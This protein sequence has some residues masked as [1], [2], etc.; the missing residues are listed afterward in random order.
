MLIWFKENFERA[1]LFLVS[2]AFLSFSIFFMAKENITGS[3]TAFV[4]FFLCLVYGNFSRFKRFKGLGF[5][6]ELWEDKQREAEALVDR[7]KSIVQIYT[8]EIVMMRVMDGN[9]FHASK[10][11][12]RWALY[13][14]L[15]AQHDT[16]GQSIDFIPLRKKMYSVMIGHAISPTIPKLNEYFVREQL[17][18]RDKLKSVHKEARSEQ[19]DLEKELLEIKDL[20][21]GT[22]TISNISEDTNPANLVLLV[23]E[24]LIGEFK[25]RYNIT[26]Q[27][28]EE[29]LSRLR[30]ISGFFE[31]GDLR[32]NRRL[33]RMADGEE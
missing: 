18:A 1:F 6:A 5:E 16:L 10:W 3:T 9:I 7:L 4:M 30:E 2:L 32:P 17:K 29:E 11:E 20:K 23:I 14:E 15:V 13:E 33:M 24:R 12:E 8:R 25:N 22:D 19:S 31:A 26:V 28:P 21:I 27:L